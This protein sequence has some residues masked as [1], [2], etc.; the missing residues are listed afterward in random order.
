M[1]TVNVRIEETGTG[2]RLSLQNGPWG[3]A[4]TVLHAFRRACQ[5]GMR[6]QATH[7]IRVSDRALPQVA[8]TLSLSGCR[9]VHY[10]LGRLVGWCLRPVAIGW[11]L[12]WPRRIGEEGS[13]PDLGQCGRGGCR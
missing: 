10:L 12:R 4:T 11:R 13:V 3:A 5:D 1:T 9:K 7:S 6:A 8:W 2:Y